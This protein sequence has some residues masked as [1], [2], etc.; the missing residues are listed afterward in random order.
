MHG[1]KSV[2]SG[3]GPLD[4]KSFVSS[5]KTTGG[6][7][8]ATD[9]GNVYARNVKHGPK[10]KRAQKQDKTNRHATFQWCHGMACSIGGT[11]TYE[12]LYAASFDANT[13]SCVIEDWLRK[14]INH[15]D[16]WIKIDLYYE[17]RTGPEVKKSKRTSAR[18]APAY[19]TYFL[20]SSGQR[21]NPLIFYVDCRCQGFN[22]ADRTAV[23]QRLDSHFK[24]PMAD[25]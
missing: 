23:I 15:V 22:S 9:Y 11:N 24:I 12:N 17:Q 2:A 10:F 1:L 7:L 6:T 3:P 8:S 19:F 4:K 25:R 18:R 16:V 20:Y 5:I 13:F 14:Q 21:A